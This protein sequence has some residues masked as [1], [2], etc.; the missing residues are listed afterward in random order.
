[1]KKI[2]HIF[3]IKREERWLA[4]FMLAFLLLFNGLMVWRCFDKFTQVG[5][6]YADVF[7]HNF[8]V[9]GF[10][11]LTYGVISDWDTSYQVYRHPLLAFYM[12]VP[13]LINQALMWLT[14]INCALFIAQLIPL[15]CGF[16]SAIFLSRIFREVIGLNECISHLLTVFYFSFG[17]VMVTAFVPDHFVISM[18]LLLMALYVSGR[19]MKSGRPLKA[20]QTVVYFLLTAGATLSNGLKIY[21]SCLFV[22]GK[23]TFRPKHLLAIILPAAL[24]WG[25]AQWEYKHYVW[26][27]EMA[28]K[29]LRAKKVKEKKEKAAREALQKKTAVL[30][31][32]ADSPAK[33]PAPAKK[34]KKR[35]RPKP[36]KPFK[37]VGFL[38]WTDATTSRSQS[39]VENI[40]GESIQLH[41]D[42]L[43]EDGL[44]S[45]PA[46]VHYQ[47]AWN[48]IVEGVVGLLFLMGIWM[49]RRSK[50]LWL[51]L[52][53]F[54]LDMAIHLGL[55]FGLNE[56][57]IMSAHYMY[58]VPIAI[59]FLLKGI[60]PRWQPYMVG[61]VAALS[62]YLLI[63]NGALVV[64]YLV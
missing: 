5:V 2:F 64:G 12:W 16:Y 24:L 30:T 34:K 19:R 31:A 57:Y 10:D 42:H 15:L 33:E 58:V 25:F 49:G 22:N 29:E 61:L 32:K 38:S 20:W 37:K 48:Y 62:L 11:P 53:Y 60:R 51:A 44:I 17:F 47:Y 40:F 36:G 14:G 50:F 28:R 54:G 4:L 26:P 41:P 52:G 9:S 63:Y 8:R 39:L 7:V 43:L 21:L 55:G 35:V 46:I 6:D 13:Y 1:M 23:R 18:L 56:V 3:V 59:G 45:R 27:R